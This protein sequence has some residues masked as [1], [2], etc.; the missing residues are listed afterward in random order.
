MKRRFSWRRIP[1]W[2]ATAAVV[3]VAPVLSVLIA[4]GWAPS[5]G[6]AKAAGASTKKTAA[7]EFVATPAVVLNAKEK[8]L[9]ANASASM[10][11]P[12]GAAPL[13]APQ[14]GEAGEAKPPPQVRLQLSAIMTQK[15][16]DVAMISG[17]P[18]RKG[19]RLGEGWT[20]REIDPEEGKVILDGPDGQ[21]R[22]L[23]LR[24]SA[25]ER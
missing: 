12:W 10:A 9:L 15:D 5:A 18:R 7:V 6:P 16:G 20:V 3:A 23:R 24:K 19:E 4:R 8:A 21:S 17:K 1:R 14:V 11:T 25:G 22:T 13:A 2:R